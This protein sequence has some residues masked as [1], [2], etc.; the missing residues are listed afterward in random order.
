VNRED[1]MEK[2]EDNT[3]NV[4]KKRSGHDMELDDPA[5]HK[6]ARE[7]EVMVTHNNKNE[8]A[9]LPGLLNNTCTET[10]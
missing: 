3:V 8:Y 4:G 5:I 9:E 7:I 6:K 1:I 10:C 2:K